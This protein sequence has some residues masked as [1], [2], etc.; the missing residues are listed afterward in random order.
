V[1]LDIMVSA[2]AALRGMRTRER[3]Q[4]TQLDAYRA[5]E[6]A[7]LR[8]FAWQRSPFYRDFHAGLSGRP[9]QELPVLTKSLLMEHFDEVV[10]DRAIRR[11][12][13]EEHLGELRGSERLLGRYWDNA[14][15]GST[16]RPGLFV[17]GRKEWATTLASYTRAP[18]WAGLRASPLSRPRTALITS[19]TPWH[20]SAR[21]ANTDGSSLHLDS[22]APLADVVD[23]LN[24]YRPQMLSA[25]ATMAGMLAEEQLQGRLRIDPAVVVTSSEVLTGHA[26][27]AI[28]QAWGRQPFNQYVAT[29]ACVLGLE[30]DR[31]TGLH[32]FEDLVIFEVTDQDTQPVAPG[33]FGSKVLV[34]VL[35]SR[36]VPLI[37]YQL[38]DSLRLAAGPCPCGRPFAVADGI[39]GRAEEILR[40]PAKAGGEVQVHPVVIHKV[41]D[42]AAAAAW[43]VIQEPGRLRVLVAGA[44]PS[45]DPAVVTTGICHALDRQGAMPLE[46]TVERIA[47]IPRGK[48]GKA[49]LIKPLPQRDRVTA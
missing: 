37:R 29:E 46:V 11:D 9:L 34:T 35:Y 10:T 12:L 1:D 40:F 42:A 8:A 13:V 3:W 25:Y 28:E 44:R 23:T 48:A 2:A 16:G 19:T 20:N 49:L 7:K 38:S 39:Q 26:R 33:V 32:L 6:L 5:R 47:A 27:R 30:C 22:A 41:M 24:G 14:T 15:S 31:H 21:L 17:F 43:Q 18:R 36:T 45:F 4:R